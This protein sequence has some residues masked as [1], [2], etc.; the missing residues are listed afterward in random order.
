MSIKII[1][2]SSGIEDSKKIQK[3][4]FSNGFTWGSKN[5]A[6]KYLDSKFF[7][8]IFS[9]RILQI[10]YSNDHDYINR[11]LIYEPN[12]YCNKIY[13]STDMDIVR[14]ILAKHKEQLVNYNPKTIIYD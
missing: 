3:Y 11:L 10:M 13:N 8:C 5:Q 4:L 12:I 2:R 7:L 1:I 6:L 14:K 9:K